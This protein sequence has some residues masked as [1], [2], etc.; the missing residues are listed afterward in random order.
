MKL[1]KRKN[2]IPYFTRVLNFVSPSFYTKLQEYKI[3][4]AELLL[5]FHIT[6]NFQKK[7][8]YFVI[9]ARIRVDSLHGYT[10]ELIASKKL[11]IYDSS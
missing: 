8:L 2:Q 7:M 11:S 6:H 5:R 1:I 3:V 10:C 9:L 4:N